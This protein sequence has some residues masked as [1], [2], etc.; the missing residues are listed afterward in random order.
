MSE[1]ITPSEPTPPIVSFPMVCALAADP[2]STDADVGHA[3]RLFM[4]RSEM[5]NDA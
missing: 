4:Y 2:T 5:M 3:F 1:P